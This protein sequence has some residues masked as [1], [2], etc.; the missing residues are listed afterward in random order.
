[1]A[2]GYTPGTPLYV[3]CRAQVIQPPAA[4]HKEAVAR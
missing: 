3:Q 2:A 1:V 4:E